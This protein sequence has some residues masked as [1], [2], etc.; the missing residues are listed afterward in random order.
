LP[1]TLQFLSVH[2]FYALKMHKNHTPSP[3]GQPA[4]EP[5]P[6]LRPPPPLFSDLFFS[7]LQLFF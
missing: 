5:L 3:A 7:P 4:C 2:T 1:T 6:G